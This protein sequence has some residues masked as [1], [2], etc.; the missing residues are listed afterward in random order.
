MSMH[1][2][3]SSNRF[4]GIN[5]NLSQNFNNSQNSIGNNSTNKKYSNN[6]KNINISNPIIDLQ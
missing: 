3:R 5:T 4:D 2:S 6:I 1:T